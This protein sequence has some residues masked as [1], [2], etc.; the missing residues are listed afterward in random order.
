[1]AFWSSEN[2]EVSAAAVIELADPI[3]A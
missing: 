3:S 2:K 1:M